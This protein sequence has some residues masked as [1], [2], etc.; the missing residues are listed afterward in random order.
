M[1]N[2]LSRVAMQNILR[3]KSPKLDLSKEG[4]GINLNDMEN[5]IIK[6]IIRGEMEVTES[7]EVNTA[8]SLEEAVNRIKNNR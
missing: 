1:V 3:E 2:P 5:N 6:G 4:K 8:I 7:K